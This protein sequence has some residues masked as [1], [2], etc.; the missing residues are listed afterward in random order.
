MTT[1]LTTIRSSRSS[2]SSTA[3]RS[4]ADVLSAPLLHLALLTRDEITRRQVLFYAAA[5]QPHN[6]VPLLEH[7]PSLGHFSPADADTLVASLFRAYLGLRSERGAHY[8]PLV[9]ANTH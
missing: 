2:R 1:T 8:T 6:A 5:N 4:F 9:F 3:R 7:A